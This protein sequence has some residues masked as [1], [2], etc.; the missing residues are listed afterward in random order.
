MTPKQADKIIRDGQPVTVRSIEY[1]DRF[2]ATFTERDRRSITS[3]DGGIYDRADLEI[4]T[5]TCPDCG[6]ERFYRDTD[7]AW[8]CPDC[9]LLLRPDTMGIGI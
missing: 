2:I 5:S 4:V 6:C 3:H 9:Q 1:G 7:G 8:D